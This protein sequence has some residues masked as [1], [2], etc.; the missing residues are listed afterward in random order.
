MELELI[1]R[2][3][4]KEAWPFLPVGRSPHRIPTT[5][6]ERRRLRALAGRMASL[7]HRRGSDPL[8]QMGRAAPALPAHVLARSAFTA[9]VT[10]LTARRIWGAILIF[11][12]IVVVCSVCRLCSA[13]CSQP[14]RRPGACLKGSRH[15]SYSLL[16]LFRSAA[17]LATPHV[18]VGNR[19]A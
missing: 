16:V 7:A 9:P 17:D 19:L 13:S 1:K 5:S 4:W 10:P 11:V 14:T 18:L 6:L 15:L 8:L 12:V 2:H 3:P